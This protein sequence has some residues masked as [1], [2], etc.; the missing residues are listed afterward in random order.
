MKVKLSS[1]FVNRSAEIAIGGSAKGPHMH[2]WIAPTPLTAI[3]ELQTAVAQVGAWSRIDEKA[4]SP[5]M[6][7]RRR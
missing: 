7:E 3:F 5:C 1:T 2:G 6:D 4:I